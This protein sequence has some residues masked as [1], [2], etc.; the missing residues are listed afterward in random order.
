MSYCGRCGSELEP[1][2]NFCP[3][4]GSPVN[5][6]SE[7][8][9]YTVVSTN[10]TVV[11]TGNTVAPV[12][13][14]VAPVTQKIHIPLYIGEQK[15]FPFQGRTLVISSGMD[16]FNHYRRLFRDYARQA[17]NS[18]TAEYCRRVVDLDSFLRDFPVMYQFF[19]KPLIEAAVNF[20]PE[21]GIYDVSLQTFEEQHTKDF[22]LCGNDMNI[23]IKSFN[24]TI[25]ANQNQKIRTYNMMP[26]LVFSGI[27]G[28]A[29]A[30]ALNYATSSMMEASIRNANVTPDQRA[31][32]FS[33]LNPNLLMEHAYLD[34][35]RIFLSMTWWMNK[36]GLDV[37]YPNDEDNQKANGLFE[38]M[39]A[40]KLPE[41]KNP[42]FVITLLQTN[43]YSDNY[44]KYV[45]WKYAG[46]EEVA[47]INKYFGFDGKTV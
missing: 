22:C 18:L 5:D 14:S 19:R 33:R 28:F 1:N 23:M 47:A 32:L 21:V 9:S 20:L 16:A 25:E 4:C 15:E 31:E 3:K 12:T 13:N 17:V 29:T 42:D 38:N 7:A 10:S 40:L 30:L 46:S 41:E 36:R 6:T 2:I 43:P 37:W 11:P 24:M 44:F 45:N 34:Y 27:G 35:W 39:C 8:V 26:G